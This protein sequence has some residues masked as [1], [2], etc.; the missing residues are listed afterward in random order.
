[1]NE[2]LAYNTESAGVTSGYVAGY[3]VAGKTGT[4]EKI[5]NDKKV[6]IFEEDYIASFCGYAPADDPQIAMLVFFDTPSGNAYYGSQVASPVFINIMSE[7]LP[8]LE[9]STDYSEEDLAYLNIPAGDY[10]N[11]STS[12]AV[13]KADNDGFIAQIV[14]EGDTV[15]SQMPSVSS[16][17]AKGGTI[18]LYTDNTTPH[19]KVTVPDFKKASAYEVNGIAASNGLNVSFNGAVSSTG[20]AVAQSV[21]EGTEV[22]KG[23]VIA[24]TFKANAEGG[25]S[26]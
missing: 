4:S 19:E 5:G 3:K 6:S 17:M 22:A 21:K 9:I 15:V 25:S 8:Y 12:E 23:T 11:I 16:K 10:T 2:I 18:I 26:D 20:I 13:D 1:M 14:G 7:V 24:V